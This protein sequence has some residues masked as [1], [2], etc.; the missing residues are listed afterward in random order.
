[1][2]MNTLYFEEPDNFLPA[3]RGEAGRGK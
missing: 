3:P 1:M 2:L